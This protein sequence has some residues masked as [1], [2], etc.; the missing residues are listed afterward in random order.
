MVIGMPNV[1]CRRLKFK[2]WTIY[3]PV[4]V[5]LVCLCAFLTFTVSRRHSL[6][7]NVGISENMK[8]TEMSEKVPRLEFYRNSNKEFELPLSGNLATMRTC[9]IVKPTMDDILY[10]NT[11]WQIQ[12][13]N[14]GQG[15]V[16]VF[17]AFYDNRPIVGYLAWIRILGVRRILEDT[18]PEPLYC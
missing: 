15:E 17:S 3:L 1:I 16:V 13:E 10:R 11:H 18:E 9:A 12:R 7:L 4:I 14:D 6:A 8:E 5:C 2:S